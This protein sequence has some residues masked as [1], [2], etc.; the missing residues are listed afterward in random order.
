MVLWNLGSVGSVVLNMVENVPATISGATMWNMTDQERIFAEEYT[1][2]AIGSVDI[3][4]KYQGALISL[5]IGDT[6]NLMNLKGVDAGGYKIGDFSV[7][8]AG[9]GGKMDVVATKWREDGINKLNAI[10]V[11]RRFGKTFG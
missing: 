2:E 4:E 3:S 10:G 6:V 1:G 7:S 9:R 5:T 8:A 11:E